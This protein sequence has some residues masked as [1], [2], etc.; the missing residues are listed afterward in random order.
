MVL[1]CLIGPK[2][3]VRKAWHSL[4]SRKCKGG[5]V[6]VTDYCSDGGIT[7]VFWIVFILDAVDLNVRKGNCPRHFS[8][9]AAKYAGE[10]RRPVAC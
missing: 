8:R 10:H 4:T 7:K 2:I 3:L 1:P 6:E 9:T 5:T